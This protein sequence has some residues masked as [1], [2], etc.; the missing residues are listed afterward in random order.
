MKLLLDQDVYA[1]TARFL[2]DEG[3]DVVRAAELGL[4]RAKDETFQDAVH[5]ELAR[6]LTLYSADE[7]QSAFVVIEPDRHRFRKLP[8]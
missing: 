5:A 2:V 8:Q 6:V 3:H 1:T 4:S 7:L